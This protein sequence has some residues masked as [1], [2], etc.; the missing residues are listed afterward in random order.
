M[1]KRKNINIA[2]GPAPFNWGRKRLLD[3]YCREIAG[4]D[5]ESVYIGNTICHKRNVLDRDDFSTICDALKA[6]GIKVYYSTLALCTTSEEFDYVKGIAHLFDGLEINMLGF[7][8]L[9]NQDEFKDTEI[10]LGP[11][12]N[13][14]N[15][16]SASFLKKFNPQRL[17]APFEISLENVAD[18]AE[19]AHIPVEVTAWGNLSTALSWRCYTARAV[20]RSRE[21]CNKVCFEYPEGMLLKTVEGE[22]IF[23]IDGLQ[24]QSAKTHCMVEHLQELAMSGISTIRIYPQMGHTKEIV[25]ILAQA[26]EGRQNAKS[27]LKQ[28]MPYAP[29]GVCN[30]WSWGK[31]G[32]EYVAA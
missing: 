1:S 12:L 30:G 18:I 4:T 19:K 22:D 2:I 23:R 8:N 7:L 28:L 20:D 9:L 27:S 25:D 26:L 32:W 17:V 11:Y 14:Y 13:I 15:W 21:N 10:I 6:K 24:V 29:S 3:F 5:V 31:A 16:K